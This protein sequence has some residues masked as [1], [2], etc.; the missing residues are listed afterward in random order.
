MRFT[1][2][3]RLVPFV[4]AAIAVAIG[5][6]LGQWQTRRAAEKIAI[7]QKLNE[8]QAAAAM[9]FNQLSGS[10]L[11]P[12]DIEY[13]R[14]LLKGE[15]LRDWPV[16]LDNRPHNGVAGFYLLMP[17]KLADSPL[18]VLV[19]RGW[20]P[21]NVADRTKMP[22]IVTPGGEIQIEGVARRDIG[23]VMQL[24]EVDPPRPHAIVQNL[25]VAGF[26]AASGLQISPVVLEQLTDTG[27][28]LVRDW[29]VP[30]TGVD[31]HRGYAFQ[32]YGLAAMAFI[33]FVVT[34]IR[35]GTK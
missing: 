12:D 13:R 14:L 35:R 25:D 7:E 20:I 2:R 23:H 34:G 28:G 18:H 19:A 17:F 9:Q 30:S 31:K 3:F 5:L 6:S 15:F 33:F 27:D 11:N 29:P 8:R 4:A 21:R 10:A 26:A 1:F 16:Y 24:G 22:A 32:W